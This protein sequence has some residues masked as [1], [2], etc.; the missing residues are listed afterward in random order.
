MYPRL[1]TGFKHGIGPSGVPLMDQ[2]L[3]ALNGIYLLASDTNN[4][5]VYIGDTDVVSRGM[6]LSSGDFISIP[7][8]HPAEIM[9]CSSGLNQKINYVLT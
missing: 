8:R 3:V 2:D 5:P 7:V 1:Y 9:V 6:P 4:S